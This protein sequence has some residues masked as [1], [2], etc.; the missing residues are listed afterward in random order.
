MA[1]YV[2]R[3]NLHK[4][5]HIE[6][7][8]YV[9]I[10]SVA[11][12]SYDHCKF[13]QDAQRTTAPSEDRMVLRVLPLSATHPKDLFDS[14]SSRCRLTVTYKI[15]YC[16]R[17]GYRTWCNIPDF[18]L[19]IFWASEVASYENYWWLMEGPHN[20]DIWK[21]I[22]FTPPMLVQEEQEQLAVIIRLRLDNIPRW[23]CH[24]VSNKDLRLARFI[25][26]AKVVCLNKWDVCFSRKR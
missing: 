5:G 19:F 2:R 12:G 24:S 3:S 25:T 17:A 7:D 1:F 9:R 11:K 26:Y 4:S 14:E 16:E 20:R 8:T 22:Q 23:V 6:G 10:L 13:F 21:V 18:S 15:F